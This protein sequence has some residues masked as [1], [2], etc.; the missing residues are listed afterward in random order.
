MVRDVTEGGTPASVLS[1]HRASLSSDSNHTLNTRYAPKKSSLES[2]ARYVVRKQN[3]SVGGEMSGW[4]DWQQ[5]NN[6]IK[7]TLIQKGLA[8]LTELG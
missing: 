4:N 2:K 8:S 3:L 6:F 5:T 1:K 7:T